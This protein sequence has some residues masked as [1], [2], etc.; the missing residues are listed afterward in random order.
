MSK[1]KISKKDRKTLFTTILYLSRS[2]VQLG[3][4]ADLS[5]EDGKA[6]CEIAA[7]VASNSAALLG[8]SHKKSMEIT[9]KAYKMTDEQSKIV[10][11]ELIKESINDE[12]AKA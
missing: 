6:V 2:F 9:K 1:F 3:A 8:Y 7:K 5:D 10:D 11:E 12:T 4:Q